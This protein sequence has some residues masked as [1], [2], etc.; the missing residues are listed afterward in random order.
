MRLRTRLQTALR[1]RI[2]T[3]LPAA[4]ETAWD[5]QSV[6]IVVEQLTIKPGIAGEAWEAGASLVGVVRAEI[7]ADGLDDLEFG[8]LLTDLAGNP[9][10]VLAELD[11]PTGTVTEAARCELFE[12]RDTI[13]DGGV[14]AALRFNLR[15][16]V[17]RRAAEVARP[18][19]MVG[20]APMIG[21]DHA[22]AYDPVEELG[23]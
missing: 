9:L 10:L 16:H 12:M 20:L 7:R 1:A 21:A 3:H 18:D 22:G 2:A 15:G 5:A 23:Q 17:M 8:A 14:A 6:V 11:V 19:L 4:L 13:R